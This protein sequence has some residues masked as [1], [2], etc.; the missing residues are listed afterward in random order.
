MNGYLWA[1]I[2]CVMLLAIGCGTETVIGIGGLNAGADGGSSGGD[3]SVG[4][5]GTSG[6]GSADGGTVMPEPGTDAGST[7]VGSTDSA[8][9]GAG[10]TDAGSSADAGQ[11]PPVDGSCVG[12]CGPYAPDA[13]CQCDPQCVKAGDCCPD[14]AS[15]CGAMPMC[16]NGK[17]DAGETTQSCP[18]DC[19]NI[20]QLVTCMEK[21]CPKQW[22][23]CDSNAECEKV[24]DCLDSC[25]DTACFQGC[26]AGVSKAVAQTLLFPLAQ[27]A[28]ASGC[29]GQPPP[30]PSNLCGNGQCDKGETA[31]SCPQDCGGGTTGGVTGCFKQNCSQELSACLQD[32]QCAA[33]AACTANCGDLACMANCAAT[34]DPVVQQKLVLP[35]G[36][37]GQQFGCFNQTTPPNLCGNG[38]CDAGETS[39][40]CPKDCPAQPANPVEACLAKSCGKSWNPCAAN[41]ACYKVAQCIQAGGVPKQCLQGASKTV[42]ELVSSWYKCGTQQGCL[43]GGNTGS[44]CG[45]GVCNATAG[46]SSANCPQDCGSALK[47]CKMK[48]DC[49]DAEVCCVQAAGQYCV[50]IGQC[51]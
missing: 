44:S 31:Q 32:K 49:A 42:N 41:A 23:A 33:V 12:K 2:G 34:T 48:S 50:A 15:V 26:T 51:N 4:G 28:Q 18:V 7:A 22:S 47:P 9:T 10:T 5:G 25:K 43:S 1:T 30:P 35:L 36:Q 39:Q 37:C 3:G 16:G 29:V 20:P 40:S 11:P 6:S 27:C 17:C 14:Y 24:L 45:D 46:E 8:T 38:K 19:P 21:S 13:A